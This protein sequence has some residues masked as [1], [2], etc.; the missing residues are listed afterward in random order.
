M[1]KT[2]KL[3]RVERN[4]TR[5]STKSY[6]VRVGG[7]SMNAPNRKEARIIKKTLLGKIKSKYSIF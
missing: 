4:I 6:R 1:T 7:T 2:I 5:E 3:G